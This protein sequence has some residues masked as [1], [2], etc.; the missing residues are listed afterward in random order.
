MTAVNKLISHFA[1]FLKPTEAAIDHICQPCL[2]V[3]LRLMLLTNF[4][5]EALLFSFF[6]LF[7][8]IK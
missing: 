8:I 4:S 2:K 3:I 1:D 6:Q 7:S 5:M